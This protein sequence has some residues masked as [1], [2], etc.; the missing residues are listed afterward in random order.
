MIPRVY[1]VLIPLASGRAPGLHSDQPGGEPTMKAGV[2]IAICCALAL[3]ALTIAVEIH[4]TVEAGRIWD[5]GR[6]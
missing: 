1:T 5:G 2:L 3:V 4:Q 6:R